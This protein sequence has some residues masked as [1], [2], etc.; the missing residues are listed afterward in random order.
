MQMV[1]S[2]IPI[3]IQKKKIKNMHLHVK[4]PDGRVLVTAPFQTP[5]EVITRFVLEKAGWIRKQ[6]ERFR[7]QKWQHPQQYIT[8]ETLHLWG[9]P[10][11]LFVIEA[12][13]KDVLQEENRILL[14]VPRGSDIKQREMIIREWY[15]DLMQIVVTSYMT[16]WA[17]ITGLC[18]SSWQIRK[19]KTRWGT[20]NTHTRKI[21]L[22]LQLAQK[23]LRCLEYVILH[24]LAHLKE[25]NHGKNFWDIVAQHM[26]EYKAVRKELNQL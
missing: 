1:I 17:Q 14:Y 11:Q 9:Q 21:W 7:C 22:N 3:E 19:M 8:G 20:C 12:E 10:F 25:N 23:P 6:Q 26:P 24:E 4:A 16:K 15:R 2:G 18:C 5:E 13:K